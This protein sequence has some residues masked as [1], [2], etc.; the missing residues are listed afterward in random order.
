MDTQVLEIDWLKE[1]LQGGNT[2]I[3]LVVLVM[4]MVA[5]T[6][7]RFMRLRKSY[8]CPHGLVEEVLTLWHKGS[9]ESILAACEKYPSTLA[10][11]VN[12][13]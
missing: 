10:T 6:V 7:E 9:Y 12:T 1:L 8:I 5:F 2:S 3:A 4:V 13:W 11:K